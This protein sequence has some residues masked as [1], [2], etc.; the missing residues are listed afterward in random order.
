[1]VESH[2]LGSNYLSSPDAYFDA[3]SREKYDNISSFLV[4]LLDKKLYVINVFFKKVI[5]LLKPTGSLII[6]NSL[7]ITATVVR[8]IYGLSVAVFGFAFD[9]IVFLDIVN[10]FAKLTHF[11]R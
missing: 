10:F 8:A 2:D 11:L 3:F 4:S 5:F 6:I 7:E 1:M 9:V